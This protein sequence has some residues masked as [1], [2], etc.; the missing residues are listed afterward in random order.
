MT[1]FAFDGSDQG[2][3]FAADKRASSYAQVD[4]ELK[5]LFEDAGTE[6]MFV[7]RLLDGGLQ[8]LDGEG[9]FAAHVDVALVSPD[10]ITGDG[11]TFEYAVR[12]AL[13]NAAIHECAG[14]A[15]IGVANDIFCCR[16]LLGRRVPTSGRWDS[17]RL[18]ARAA[19]SS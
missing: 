1:A 5:S 19:R 11:H 9:V 8:A 6:E 4:A 3:F 18:H 14:V 7:L 10:G 17:P 15:F 12:I 2:R 16:H 13:Q